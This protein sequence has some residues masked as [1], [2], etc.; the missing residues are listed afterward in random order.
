MIPLTSIL[1]L[2]RQKLLFMY[3]TYRTSVRVFAGGVLVYYRIIQA[4]PAVQHQQQQQA[5][6]RSFHV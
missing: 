5:A 6:V 3:G 4:V 1:V 2:R